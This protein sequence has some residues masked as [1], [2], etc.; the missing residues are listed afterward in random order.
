[1]LDIDHLEHMFEASL[2]VSFSV[3]VTRAMLRKIK[4]WLAV[5]PLRVARPA[6]KP[7]KLAKP[8]KPAATR[9]LPLKPAKL[10]LPVAVRQPK[11]SKP[12]DVVKKTLVKKPTI[13]VRPLPQKLLTWQKKP[14]LTVGS[15]CSGLGTDTKCLASLGVKFQNVFCSDSDVAARQV[16][17]S[18]HPPKSLHEDCTSPARQQEG[19][20]DIYTVGWPCQPF[21]LAGKHAGVL[22]ERAR[23][24]NII[25]QYI[26]KR[27]P[28]IFIGENVPGLLHKRH[29]AT[30]L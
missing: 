27:Q 23:P 16:L 4:S 29:K 28:A 8:A 13:L 9:P 26:A 25:K 5:K 17:A 14:I 7:L 12:I 3:K 10:A 18:G 24:L 1:M 21:S 20:V 2:P 15:D 11:L 30:S 22:D 19:P 6:V